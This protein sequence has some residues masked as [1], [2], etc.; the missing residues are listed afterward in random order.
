LLV[1]LDGWISNGTL[2][3]ASRYPS[4]S[5]GTLV[6]PAIDD[7][8]FPRL[9]GFA[10]TSRLARPTVI[11]SEE[12]PPTK[13]AGLSGFRAE[14]RC[15]WPRY[16]RAAAA[17]AGSAC[18]DPHRLEPAQG[19]FWAKGELCDNN[20]AMISFAATREERLKNNDPRLS[21]AERYPN[22]AD[23][24]GAIAKARSQLVQ[25]RLLLK[26]TPGCS[27]QIQL[28]NEKL[29]ALT[30]MRG[31]GLRTETRAVRRGG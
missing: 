19:R 22:E 8:G 9:P 26:R 4:R 16:C 31:S 13:G 7:V 25:D 11:K 3:P 15:R 10:Y 12:M 27:R 24:A 23:R 18:G 28:A 30:S 29:F 2:P 20:G 17:D 21:M 1:A 6:L 5:D 14:D